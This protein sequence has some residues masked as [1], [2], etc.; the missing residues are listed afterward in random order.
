MIQISDIPLNYLRH[1]VH[2][3]MTFLH[4]ILQWT[5][6]FLATAYDLEKYRPLS[7]RDPNISVLI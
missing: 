7:F 5:L 1:A 2:P 6:L 3:Y 4:Y